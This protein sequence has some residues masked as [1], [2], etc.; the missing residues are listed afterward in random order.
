MGAAQTSKCTLSLEEIAQCVQSSKFSADEV[1]ALW[2]HFKTINRASEHITIKQFQASM[3]FKDSALLDRIFRVFDADQD[4]QISFPEYLSCMSSISSKSSKEDKLKFS[5]QIYDFDGDG[6]I[7]VGDLT[8]VLAATLREHKLKIS[9][10]DIDFVVQKTMEEAAPA[11]PNMISL[12]EYTV[13]V[14]TRPHMMDHLTINI[15]S[16]I[17]E[18]ATNNTIALATPRGFDSASNLHAVSQK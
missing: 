8:A 11:T 2:F 15:S 9:R 16:I 10:E 17:Q 4:N 18:Y 14:E 1:K 12:P 6:L 7:S 3:L 13:L 5:F